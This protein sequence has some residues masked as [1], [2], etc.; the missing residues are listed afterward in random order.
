MKYFL[1][2]I[3][4][5]RKKEGWSNRASITYIQLRRIIARAMMLEAANKSD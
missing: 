1:E 4:Y 2:A 3:E 5:F